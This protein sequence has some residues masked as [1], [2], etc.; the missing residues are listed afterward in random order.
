M[1]LITGDDKWHQVALA[2]NA[3]VYAALTSKPGRYGVVP[4]AIVW[5]DCSCG[6]LATSWVQSWLSTVFPAEDTNPQGNCDV[7]W[8]VSEFA[9]QIVRCAPTSDDQ[10]RPP[11][12]DTLAKAALL[13]A[14][15][16][17]QLE[18][19]VSKLLCQ[20]LEDGKIIDF[21]VNR[22]TTQGPEGGCV[23][24][25]LRFMVGLGRG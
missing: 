21:M 8:E 7:P 14:V 15:D 3:A 23:G 20:M 9:V 13:M 12:T 10:G 11:S 2:A 5:D 24:S 16:G 18:T 25:E 4:G 6:L 1:P 17:N 22:R 19:S